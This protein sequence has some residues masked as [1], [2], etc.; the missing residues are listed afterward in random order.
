MLG[1]SRQQSL[2][3]EPICRNLKLAFISPVYKKGDVKICENYRPISIT[4]IFAELFE[5]IL[6]NQVNEFMQK[7]EILNGTQFGFQ[8]HKS[9]TDAVLHLIEALQENYD[10]L[11]I[12][13]AVFIDLAKAFIS[14]SHEIFLKTIEAY[15]FS[16][17][18]VDLFASFLKNRQQCFK[19]NDVYSEWLETN[20]DVPQG[21]VLGPLVF[22]LYI[23]DFREK[24]YK[25]TST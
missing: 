2:Q 3:L 17:S 12:S 5:R 1:Q 16:E 18:A 24:R 6:L 21:T 22:L 13:V 25:E 8:K 23:N 9:S 7:E 11:K 10:N 19:I 14:K 4:P 20:H 15:G